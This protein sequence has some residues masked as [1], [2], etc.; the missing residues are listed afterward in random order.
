MRFFLHL[1]STHYTPFATIFS[2][3]SCFR[4]VFSFDIRCAATL[5]ACIIQATQLDADSK[6][7]LT[8]L[9][10]HLATLPV[11][12]RVGKMMLYGAIFG[13]VEPAITIAAAM[14]CRNPFVAPFDK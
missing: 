8:A 10:F 13:C 4:R 2:G 9:G 7:V 3:L 1:L 14:S 6:P 12:P 5:P 11:E